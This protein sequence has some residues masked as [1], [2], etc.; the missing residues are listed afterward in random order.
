MLGFIITI[1]FTEKTFFT[2]NTLKCV[3]ISK[4]ECHDKY[5]Q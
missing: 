1:P 3:S 5:Q 4:Q 2:C